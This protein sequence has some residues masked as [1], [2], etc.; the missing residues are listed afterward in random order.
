MYSVSVNTFSVGINWDYWD[1]ENDNY[2]EPQYLSFKE[3]IM[4]YKHIDNVMKVYSS[5]IIPKAEA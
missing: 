3:E 5:E 1:E 2:V 4:E